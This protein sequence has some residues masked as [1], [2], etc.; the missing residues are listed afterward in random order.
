MKFFIFISL[1]GA[2]LL[3]ITLHKGWKKSDQATKNLPIFIEN[4]RQKIADSFERPENVAILFSFIKG[5]KN[6]LSPYTKNAFKKLNLSYLLSPSGIHF[7]AL[8]FFVGF[9]LKKIK[10]KKLKYLS[11]VSV[12]LLPLYF[13][14]Y[15]AIKRLSL[16]RL[17]F[18]GKFLTKSKVTVEIIFLVTFLISFLTGS[19]SRSPLGFIYSYIFLG[20]FFS[21]RNFSKITLI[22]GLFSSQL[23]VA[24]FMGDKVSLL[25]IPLGLIFSFLFSLIFP[26]LLL[27]I[28]SF[29]MIPYN[30]VEPVIRVFVLTVHYSA[31]FLN[32]SFTSSSLFLIA[33]IW[34]LMMMVYSKKKCIAI[35]IL[36]FLHTNTAMTPVQ[37]PPHAASNAKT[38]IVNIHF[39]SSSIQLQHFYRVEKQDKIHS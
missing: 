30:W 20:T 18:K 12:L 14:S 27:F 34:C 10:S 5:D 28:S 1:S 19:F 21:L 8:L 7:S 9:F 11:Q 4:Y 36:I 38:N 22:L 13:S 37:F 31:K 15:E 32:G 6:H 2:L 39:V 16:L 17:L 23:I 29:W 24:L 35:L 26:I 3:G 33:A 25:S